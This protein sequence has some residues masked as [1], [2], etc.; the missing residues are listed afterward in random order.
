MVH[1]DDANTRD[2]D[3][4]DE[5]NIEFPEFGTPEGGESELEINFSDDASPD[6]DRPQSESEVLFEAAS[7]PSPKDDGDIDIAE[8]IELDAINADAIR[9]ISLSDVADAPAQS[10]ASRGREPNTFSWTAFLGVT[11]ALG[12]LAA[13]IAVP[14]SYFGVETLA[15]MHPAMQA[16]L[17]AIAFGPTLLIWLGAA[18]VGEAAKARILASELAAIARDALIPAQA[19][20]E[21]A[22]RVTLDVTD[23]I[24]TLNK[25]VDGAFT[26]LQALNSA[27]VKHARM[28][29]ETMAQVSGGAISASLQSERAAFAELNTDLKSQTETLAHTIGRQV[30]LMREASKLVK[31]E[32]GDAEEALETHL[33][34]FRATASVISEGT[35]ELNAAAQTANA[36]SGRLDET[37][38]SALSTLAEATK[39]TDAA[40]QST[41]DA[42]HAANSTAQA[43]RDTTQRAISDAKRVAEL[44]REE[45]VAMQ[46]AAAS[47][48]ET[49]RLAA[50]AARLSADDA[51]AAA[52]KHAGAIEKRLAALAATAQAAPQRNRKDAAPQAERVQEA[53]SLY[54]AASRLANT[55]VPASPRTAL[56]TWNNV[57]PPRQSIDNRG[58]AGDLV[59][60][61]QPVGDDDIVERAFDL[62]ADAGVLIDSAFTARDLDVIAHASRQGAVARR[63]AVND[64]AGIGVT[65]VARL[66]RRDPV[67]RETALAFRGR[68][69]LA[70]ADRAHGA[71]GAHVVRAYLLIDSAIG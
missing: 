49:L 23:E 45:T 57:M 44:I 8:E 9:E 46:E 12:W 26:R 66:I 19:P 58:A 51:Q 13:A 5:S 27:A 7:T 39:L 56:A 67:A 60:F 3:S 38:G 25:A 63:R 48:L 55:P 34:G 36:A 59:S 16:G 32:L 40:R 37:I 17:A 68:P 43:V 20:A 52:D 61:Q 33:N 24:A 22:K 4:A 47:T 11:A 41:Q 29:E 30:R 54:E 71:K 69:D 62:I 18:A 70:K 35:A 1:L 53:G 42:V 10:A 65:R 21:A 28:F 14:V 15:A 64:A 50:D 31:T 6:D 2:A